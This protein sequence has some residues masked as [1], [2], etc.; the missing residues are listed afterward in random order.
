MGWRMRVRI[1]E[2]LGKWGGGMK[3]EGV[4]WVNGEGC[5]RI[6]VL[7]FDIADLMS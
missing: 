5:V 7:G 3:G 6:T 4:G 2:G 1:N